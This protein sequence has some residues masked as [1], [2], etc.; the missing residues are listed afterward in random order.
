M[1]I[2]VSAFLCATLL[3]APSAGQAAT[4]QTDTAAMFEA[5]AYDSTT[6]FAPQTGTDIDGALL[7]VVIRGVF[8]ALPASAFD[9]RKNAQGLTSRTDA[10]N[11]LQT[12]GRSNADTLAHVMFR[13]NKQDLLGYAT[14]TTPLPLSFEVLRAAAAGRGSE[15]SIGSGLLAVPV[16]AALPLLI[17]AL[18]LLGILRGR[19]QNGARLVAAWTRPVRHIFYRKRHIRTLWRARA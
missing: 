16:P 7:T 5:V 18:A 13:L 11:P 14:E 2:I 12:Q 4:T 17:G 10:E 9:I 1:R 6:Y 8:A 19:P 3:A 15:H